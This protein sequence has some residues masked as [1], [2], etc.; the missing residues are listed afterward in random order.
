MNFDLSTT[1]N[2]VLLRGTCLGCHAQGLNTRIV[3][4][5]VPQVRHTDGTGD[6]A[7]GNF[8]YLFGNWDATDGGASAS[9]VGHNVIDFGVAEAPLTR[10]PGDEFNTGIAPFG[11]GGANFT[12]AGLNGCH[13]DRTVAGSMAGISGSHHANAVGSINAPTSPGQSYRFLNGVKGFE[14]TRWEDVTSSSAHN[15]YFGVVFGGAVES[16]ATTPGAATISGFCGECHGLFHGPTVGEVWS[17]TQWL[18]HPTDAI[19]PNTGEYNSYRG[20]GAALIYDPLAPI[21]KTAAPPVAP[22]AAV[23]PGTDVVTCLSCHKAHASANA[24]I[25]RWNY[26]DI[27]TGTGTAEYA[28]CFI[29]HTAKD[30]VNN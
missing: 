29:C 25:L 3:G 26:E 18:R 21:G 4:G 14:D 1:P 6:L 24:D 30:N 2:P 22:V 9:T 13:G 23:I 12:C 11:Q 20:S 15:V 8:R 27:A 5:Y 19:L 28:R 10:P 16:T 7:G 17:S